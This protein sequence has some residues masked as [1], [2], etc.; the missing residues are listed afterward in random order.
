MPL[1][2][3][4]PFADP[5]IYAEPTIL[6]VVGR[7]LGDSPRMCQLASDTPRQGSEYQKIHRDTGAL[8]PDMATEPPPYQL[9]V[10]FPL[11]DVKSHASGPLEIV[12][13]T[14]TWT[15]AEGEA[16]VARGEL[17]ASPVWMDI[18]DVLIRDV[19]MLH[20]GTPN[21]SR[22]GRP[23]VVIGYSRSWWHRP[24]VGLKIARTV[25]RSLAPNLQA[26]VTKDAEIVDDDKATELDL[27]RYD[28]KALKKTS[29][30]SFD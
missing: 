8:F 2:F 4:P 12:A 14:H 9:A 13:G 15:V 11:V 23:M 3:L 27:E 21:Q 22:E 29:G 25:Y 30:G 1:P 24:E 18:G 5:D 26:L 7:V 28:V 16:K 10:N 6:A 20:R 17:K 19:R